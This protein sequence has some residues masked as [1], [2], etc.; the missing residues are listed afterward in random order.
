MEVMPR[1]A[2]K[3]PSR[4]KAK[5]C[6]ACIKNLEGRTIPAVKEKGWA[7]HKFDLWRGDSTQMLATETREM[8]LKD[9]L[10]KMQ[11]TIEHKMSDEVVRYFVALAEEDPMPVAFSLASEGTKARMRR[12]EDRLLTEK[13]ETIDWQTIFEEAVPLEPHLPRNHD[14]TGLAAL[15]SN[16]TQAVDDLFSS[17]IAK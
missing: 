8:I 14:T 5:R 7:E 12:I 15:T 9:D 13:L 16:I 11:Q 10:D 4:H 1:G 3:S 2:W 6:P 17:P